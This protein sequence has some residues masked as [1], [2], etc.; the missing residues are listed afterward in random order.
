MLHSKKNIKC[1]KNSSEPIS[2]NS[3]SPT[4]KHDNQRET[5]NQQN[6]ANRETHNEVTQ[7]VK[8][9]EPNGEGFRRRRRR[10]RRRPQAREIGSDCASPLRVLTL[11]LSLSQPDYQKSDPLG[12]WVLYKFLIWLLRKKIGFP[13]FWVFSI[14]MKSYGT[15]KNHRST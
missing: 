1:K 6:Q 3:S 10:R 12:F 8:Q 7:A 11:S 4:I 13:S 14:C 5:T 9:R 15:T 2:R